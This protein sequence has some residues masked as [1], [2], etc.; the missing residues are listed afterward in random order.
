[1]RTEVQMVPLMSLVV[2]ILVS[3][4]IAFFASFLFHMVLPFHRNDL[5]RLSNEGE[6]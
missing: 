3:A 4:V 5:R 2:P 1:M 6:V